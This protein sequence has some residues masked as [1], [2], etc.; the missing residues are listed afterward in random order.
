MNERSNRKNMKKGSVICQQGY[1]KD[2][3][4][5]KFFCIKVLKSSE[6]SIPNEEC[7]YRGFIS[8]SIAIND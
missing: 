4:W 6:N 3:C 8:S 7:V 2:F 1:E 5:E